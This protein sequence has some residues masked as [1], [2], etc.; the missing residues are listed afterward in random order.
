MPMASKQMETNGSAR[1]ATSGANR[2]GVRPTPHPSVQDGS[3]YKP[4]NIRGMPLIPT[5][6]RGTKPAPQPTTP[7]R[8]T[9]LF[10]GTS[11]QDTHCC[12]R[13]RRL[14]LDFNHANQPAN[15]FREIGLAPL[16]AT[17]M[18]LKASPNTTSIREDMVTLEASARPPDNR[19]T[20]HPM[21]PSARNMC[22]GVGHFHRA[23]GTCAMAWVTF[24][25]RNVISAQC[26]ECQSE[27][28]QPSAGKRRE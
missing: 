22:H 7:F 9:T 13:H 23:L 1:S 5:R 19:T 16:R 17:A 25:E 27:E 3:H 10:R 28:I 24:T 4:L 18:P 2:K 21:S 8:G 20:Q 14:H 26:S 15:H 12:M 6:L 11:L